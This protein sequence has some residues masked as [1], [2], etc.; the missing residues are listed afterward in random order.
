MAEYKITDEDYPV[1][2]TFPAFVHG[3]DWNWAFQLMDDDNVAPINTTGYACVM[4]IK[5]SLN[6]E[7][8]AALSIGSGITMTA[9]NGLFTFL[10]DDAAVDAYDWTTAIAKIVITDDLGGKTPLFVGDLKFAA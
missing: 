5:A 7:T 9:A 6:G 8:Y 10:I 3:A 2:V 4:T 1:Q